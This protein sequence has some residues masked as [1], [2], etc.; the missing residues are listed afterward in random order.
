VYPSAD[1]LKFKQA[2]KPFVAIFAAFAET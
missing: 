2:S 1:P